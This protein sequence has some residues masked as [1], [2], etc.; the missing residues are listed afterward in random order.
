MR[1][2]LIGGA[3]GAG[4]VLDENTVALRVAKAVRAEVAVIASRVL[5]LNEAALELIAPVET[6]QQRILARHVVGV[7]DAT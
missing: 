4:V 2:T 3:V 1:S 6:A 7:V 5:I